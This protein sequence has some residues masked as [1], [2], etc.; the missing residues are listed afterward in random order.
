MVSQV[1]AERNVM[2]LSRNPYVVRLYY[3]FQNKEHLYL[4]MEYLIGGAYMYYFVTVFSK[5]DRQHIFYNSKQV[6]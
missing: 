3:A 5:R 6:I 1:L 4:V 2:A